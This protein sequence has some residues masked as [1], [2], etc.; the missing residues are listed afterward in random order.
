MKNQPF[1]NLTLFIFLGCFCINSGELIGQELS[2]EEQEKKDFEYKYFGNE[3]YKSAAELF[4][5]NDTEKVREY[6][7]KASET[8]EGEKNWLGLIYATKDILRTF[9]GTG[10]YDE[11]IRRGHEVI[12]NIEKE[13]PKFA[14]NC[15]LIYRELG[16][17][18]HEKGDLSQGLDSYETAL[19]IMVQDSLNVPITK[20]ANIYNEIGVSYAYSGQ[21]DKTL[22]YFLKARDTDLSNPKLNDCVECMGSLAATYGNLGTFYAITGNMDKSFEY[23][24]K[25]I[26]LTKKLEGENS[27]NLFKDYYNMGVNYRLLHEFETSINYFK[28]SI[29]L[30]EKSGTTKDVYLYNSLPYAYMGLGEAFQ[31]SGQLEEAL[32]YQKKTAEI[33]ETH[34]NG[35]SELVEALL[36]VSGIYIEQE[37]FEL[38][39]SIMNKADSIFALIEYD[40]MNIQNKNQVL[41][42]LYLNYVLYY[43]K[44][45]DFK[46]AIK[47]ADLSYQVIDE[48][49]KGQT[50]SGISVLID[51]ANLFELDQQLDSA[52]YYNQKALTAA[53]YN[54]SSGDYHDLP[55]SEELKD[56]VETY[57]VLEQKAG[58]FRK[59]ASLEKE[60]KSQTKLFSDAISAIDLAD[61]V[62]IQNLKKL[63][64][65]RASQSSRTIQ[66]SIPVYQKGLSIAYDFYEHSGLDTMLEKGFYY[67]QKMKAQTLWLTHLKSSASGFGNLDKALLEK[68][69]DLL[70]D[71]NYYENL[72]FE[73]RQNKDTAT[74]Q[75]YE[76]ENL[77]ALRESYQDL[78]TK[79]EAEYPEYYESKFAFAPETHESLQSILSEEELLIEYV[80]T[81]SEIF[82]FTIKKEEPLNLVKIKLNTETATSIQSLSQMLQNSAMMRKSSREKFIRLS[83]ELYNQFILPIEKQVSESQKIVVV[84]D[85]FTNYI[86][87]EILLKSNEIKPFKELD[88]LI[89]KHEFSYHYSSTL[90]AQARRK[91]IAQNLGIFAF[92]PVYDDLDA[93]PLTMRNVEKSV[94]TNTLRAF[95]A[96]GS[97]SPL[98]ESE[99]EVLSISE[100]FDKKDKSN[101]NLVAIR[102]QAV[103]ESLKSNLEKSY[104]FVHIAGHSFADLENP[105]FSGIACFEKP[106]SSSEDGIL[107]T[108]EIYNIQSK[109]DLVTLSS[110]ESG[111][112][113]LESSEGIL[114]LNRAFIYAGTPNVVFS[115]WKVYDK[116]SA[117]LMVDFYKNILTGK[118]YS[119]SLRA[120]KLNLLKNEATA[121]PHFWSPYLLIGR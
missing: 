95:E 54:F 78:L 25:G 117:Q 22:E 36:E 115:L 79:M 41:G 11:V 51:L 67:T 68:E 81:D 7:R 59:A 75:F 5:S 43:K 88:F 104:Q 94:P 26:E 82:A 72:V 9:Q 107:Y 85:G 38:G 28:K 98:P 96:D 33:F 65:I 121:A 14:K 116:V 16:V 64:V 17:L 57:N 53:S 8:F 91:P 100:L 77:F 84:G 44:K 118:N 110:C 42:N 39:S 46:N 21:L 120:A 50:M 99:T 55:P 56:F 119:A 24:E 4:E 109:A 61:Q 6:L 27:L 105:K 13:A 87:F 45:G 93:Q 108:G 18:Y 10:D 76:T 80:V 106:D 112:G 63:N 32:F 83:N 12:E 66:N 70:S 2:K 52:F 15:Y 111:Y 23:S 90:F 58:L 113:K 89:K 114:G 62:H 40:S 19:A 1:I 86:P 47:Y 73:A 101:T 48:L 3:D 20:F 74:V 35:S 37:E 97:F 92:A 29:A 71:I 69:R 31:A 103:E 102:E 30:I 49:G 60:S 34:R